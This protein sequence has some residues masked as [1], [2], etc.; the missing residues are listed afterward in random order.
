MEGAKKI[1]GGRLQLSLIYA[2]A[3]GIIR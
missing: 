3:L 2:Y 1:T